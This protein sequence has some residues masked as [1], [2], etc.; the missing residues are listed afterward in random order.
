MF[1]DSVKMVAK[2]SPLL[3]LILLIYTINFYP[4]QLVDSDDFKMW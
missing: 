4:F 1:L 2:D 3:H